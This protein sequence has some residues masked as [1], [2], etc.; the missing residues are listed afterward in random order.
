MAE[1]GAAGWDHSRGS[2]TVEDDVTIGDGLVRVGL[3]ESAEIEFGMTSHV[4]QR[5]RNRLSGTVDRVSGVGDAVVAL[6]RGLAGPNGPV[7]IQA[8]VTVPTAKSAIG[9]G[10]VGGGVLLP[11]GFDLPAGFSLA[12]TPEIDLVGDSDGHGRHIAWGSAA[13]VSHALDP[14]ITLAV[15]VGA[16][17]DNDPGNHS[18]DAR[19]AG[20]VAWQPARNFQLDLEFDAGIAG[21]APDRSI[22]IG[23]AHLFR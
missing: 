16:Y 6:R 22:L 12:I 8:F 20:S 21:G 15:E 4:S 17:R 1:I 18:T 3:A 13:G 19:L 7:A 11:A 14:D 10:L 5:T 2:L 23:F 9:A